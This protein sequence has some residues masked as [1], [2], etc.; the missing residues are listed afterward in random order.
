MKFSTCEVNEAIGLVLRGVKMFIWL[1]CFKYA[2][3]ELFQ[4]MVEIR[5]AMRKPVFLKFVL[6]TK[7]MPVYYAWTSSY[8]DTTKWTHF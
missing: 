8:L 6:R 5:L 1:F 7:N 3:S 2:R 4:I